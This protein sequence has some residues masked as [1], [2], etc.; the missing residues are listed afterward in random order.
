[1]A[2]AEN[3]V[4]ANFPVK[5][6]TAG[7]DKS[8]VGAAVETVI[9]QF[10]TVPKTTNV[11]LRS[12]EFE[13]IIQSRNNKDT[14]GNRAVSQYALNTNTY[15]TQ[16]RQ[17][18]TC[19]AGALAKQTPTTKKRTAARQ[20]THHPSTNWPTSTCS[21]NLADPTARSCA[22]R[23]RVV[24][25]DRQDCAASSVKT[26]RYCAAGLHPGCCPGATPRALRWRRRATHSGRQTPYA[27]ASSSSITSHEPRRADEQEDGV[28]CV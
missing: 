7:A 13:V 14:T 9:A 6:D 19:N 8:A 4:Q 25:S 28:R 17:S 24:Q 27:T 20:L 5:Q 22:W 3:Q 26:V 15:A 12:A 23:V 10:G 18:N 11:L 2:E 21:H 1:M 16:M